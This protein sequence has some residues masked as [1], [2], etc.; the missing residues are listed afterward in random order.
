MARRAHILILSAALALGGC[1]LFNAPAP[2]TAPEPTTPAVPQTLANTGRAEILWDTFGVP[3]VVAQDEGALFYAFGWAQMRNH[4]DLML[5]LYGQ[6]RG[7]AAE[8]WGEQYVSSDTW[9]LTNGI[10]AR[11]VQWLSRQ[12]AHSRAYLEAFVEANPLP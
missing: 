7:R 4:A 12:P 8:Y 3:H 11:A 10:P 5:R 6:A 2:T 1:S 9:V